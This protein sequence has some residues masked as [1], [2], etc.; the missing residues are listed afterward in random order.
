MY[1][2]FPD[3]DVQCT[4]IN[5]PCRNNRQMPALV[6]SPKLPKKNAPGI[7][8]IH[9]GGYM[10]GKKWYICQEPLIW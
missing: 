8:W 2:L 3:R 7:L 10:T 9:G 5:I 1:K 6:V 4:R